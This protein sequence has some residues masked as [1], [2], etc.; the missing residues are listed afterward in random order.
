MTQ[1]NKDKERRKANRIFFPM[2]TGERFMRSKKDYNRQQSKK[3][4]RDHVD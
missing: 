2:N 4:V 1:K 3:E